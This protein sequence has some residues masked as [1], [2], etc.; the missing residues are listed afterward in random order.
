[1]TLELVGIENVVRV[2]KRGV[3]G[4][5]IDSDFLSSS[6]RFLRVAQNQS[7]MTTEAGKNKRTIPPQI[8]EITTAVARRNKK[9]KPITSDKERAGKIENDDTDSSATSV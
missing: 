2:W 1:V 9:I 3:D 6:L 7:L 8:S 4:T 5:E